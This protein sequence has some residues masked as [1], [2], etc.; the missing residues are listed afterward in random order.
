MV[1]IYKA[2]MIFGSKGHRNIHI[3]L[4]Y[5]MNC[6]S[7]DSYGIYNIS[8]FMGVTTGIQELWV[9]Q[10]VCMCGDKMIPVCVC[11]DKEKANSCI[12]T[13]LSSLQYTVLNC[14]R[15]NQ[16]LIHGAQMETFPDEKQWQSTG[17]S[18]CL[19]RVLFNKT[20]WQPA[21]V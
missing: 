9:F 19:C 10:C 18:W 5:F 15:P 3:L 7:T 1:T 20:T 13:I 4:I 2:L 17:R 16:P 6:S 11:S 8:V 14:I 21:H 12:S